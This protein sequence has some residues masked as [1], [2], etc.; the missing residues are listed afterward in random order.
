MNTVS[1]IVK[2]ILFVWELYSYHKKCNPTFV[3]YI[4]VGLSAVVGAAT[5]AAA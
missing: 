3:M 1:V 4:P 5:A 2:N